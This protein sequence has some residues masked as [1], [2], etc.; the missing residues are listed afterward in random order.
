[1]AL[2]ATL[3]KAK[4]RLVMQGNNF[5]WI[6]YKITCH[7]DAGRIYKRQRTDF[8]FVNVSTVAAMMG[9]FVPQHDSISYKLSKI[10]AFLASYS[11]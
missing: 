3:A 7:S 6:S 10:F 11:S 5:V 8:V 2:V 1:M 4:M 9:C